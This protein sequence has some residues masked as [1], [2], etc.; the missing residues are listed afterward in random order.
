MMVLPEYGASFENFRQPKTRIELKATILEE[1]Q[2]IPLE[3]DLQKL[4]HSMKKRLKHVVNAK[5]G[6]TKY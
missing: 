5:G 2:K 3:Y 1:W 6:H 4:V